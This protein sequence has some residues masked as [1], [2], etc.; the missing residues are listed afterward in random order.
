MTAAELAGRAFRAINSLHSLVYFVPEAEEEF[1]A[2]GLRP[3]SM[4]YFASRSAPMGPVSPGVTTATFYN[5]SPAM[6]ARHIPR[7]W[8][9]ASPADVLAARLRVADRALRRLLGEAVTSA[10]VTE[11]GAL[12]REAT[13]ALAPEGRALYAGHADLPWPD[14]PHLVMWHAITLLREYRG[15]GHIAALVAAGLSGIDALITHCATGRGMTMQAAQR[16]RGWTDEQWSEALAG[17]NERGLLAGEQLTDAG[18][19]LRAQVERDTDRMDVAAWQHLG[20][21]RTQ[22]LIELG[23]SLSRTVTA[24]GAFPSGVFA[25]PR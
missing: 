3:G 2:I 22:R 12:A 18:A 14:E 23:K 1:T 20:E 21:E 7:A 9:L 15:D 19:D 6:V 11:L 13:T 4:P 17:L 16:L 5:F 24:N 25:I 8:T 10:E